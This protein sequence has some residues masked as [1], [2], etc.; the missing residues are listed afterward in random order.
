MSPVSLTITLA[1]K[2]RKIPIVT[3]SKLLGIGH[4]K[5]LTDHDPE[6][7]EHNEGTSDPMGGHLGGVDG[8]CSVLCTDT[9]THDKT[10]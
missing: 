2:P 8:D 9:D 1:Q 10:R 3:I 7:P 6:L 4:E 5:Q